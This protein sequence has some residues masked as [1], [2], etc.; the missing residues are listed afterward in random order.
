MMLK[1][2]KKFYGRIKNLFKP[3]FSS[4]EYWQNRYETGGNSGSGSYNHLAIY[5]AEYLNA[6]AEDNKI[7]S[8]IEFGCGD[9]NQIKSFTFS[10]YIGLDVAP[11]SIELCTAEFKDDKTKSFFL[12]D[13]RYFQD[14][15]GVFKF[16]LAISLDVLY[17][18]IE[19][20]VYE[21]YLIHLFQSAKKFVLIYSSNENVPA[22]HAQFHVKE[23]VFT[24][25]VERL[26]PNFKFVRR[27]ENKYS[28]KYYKD[29]D[30]GSLSDFFLFERI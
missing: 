29:E 28:T 20:D 3:Q 5:K 1:L 14:N 25:D 30:I 23:R 16:D 11:K 2:A 26:I 13:N 10:N 12:Y 21:S 24:N 6:F 7:N 8:V 4:K 19:Q 22:A 15:N 18:L 9:G 17:H 27:D